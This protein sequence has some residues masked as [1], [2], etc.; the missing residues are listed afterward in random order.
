VHEGGWLVLGVDELGVDEL[1]WL[2]LV[3]LLV[4]CLVRL[5]AAWGAVALAARPRAPTKSCQQ[6]N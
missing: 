4:A 3:R 1:D 2:V 6:A 5:L